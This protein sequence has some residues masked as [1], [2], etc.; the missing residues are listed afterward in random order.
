MKSFEPKDGAGGPTEGRGRNQEA[1]FHGEKR[2][3]ETH[4]SMTD[5]E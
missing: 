4:A 1:D 5:P 2:A 3:N